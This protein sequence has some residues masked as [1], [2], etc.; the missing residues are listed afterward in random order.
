M[1]A[2]RPPD[3]GLCTESPLRAGEPFFPA[4]LGPVGVDGSAHNVSLP[5]IASAGAGAVQ[6]D[7]EGRVAR[8]LILP[9][10]PGLKQAAEVAEDIGAVVAAAALGIPNSVVVHPNSGIFIYT[11]LLMSIGHMYSFY[12]YIHTL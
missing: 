3:S 4:R 9:V 5:D 2:H 11:L 6:L 12:G 8:W 7:G 1:A 10:P